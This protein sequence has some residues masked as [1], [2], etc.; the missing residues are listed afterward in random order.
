MNNA[1]QS[2]LRSDFG[3]STGYARITVLLIALCCVCAGIAI[4]AVV[5]QITG[6]RSD[7][8]RLAVSTGPVTPD[9]LSLAFARAANQV[10]PCVAHIKVAE[11]EWST[12]EG[13]GSGVIVN[14]AG[15]ILT[16]A[17]VI[18][19]AA[20]IRVKLADG[21]EYD[22]RVVG[23]DVPTDLAVLKIQAP[24]PLPAA[25]MGDSDK[26]NVGDWVLAI[27]SPFGLKQTVTAG[28]ISARDREDDAGGTPFQQFLQTDA[29]IN[30][31][32]SGGP[33]VNLGGEVIGINTQIATPTGTYS[34]IG[35]ALPSSTAVEIYNQLVASG[36]VRRAFLGVTP[37]EMTPQIA[38]LNRISDGQGVVIREL[39]SNTGPAAR[40]G[41][42]SGDVVTSINGNKVKTVRE[43]IRRIASLPVGSVASIEY[44]RAGE[45]RTCS[46]KLEERQDDSAPVLQPAV[47]PNEKRQSSPAI[48]RRDD[49]SGRDS[50]RSALGISVRSITNDF[51]RAEGLEGVEGA[52]ITMVE[53]G[54]IADRNGLG[55]E[56][57]IVDI[58]NKS[59]QSD[60]DFLKATRQLRSGDDVV[61]KVLRRQRGPLRRSWIVSFTMP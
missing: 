49:K 26:L 56:D 18:R 39:T 16:N 8:N 21:T 52:Y 25:R 34:G 59:I 23:T 14:E 41:L 61:I 32:N 22:A 57:I 33:L 13:S 31:G 7:D 12:R 11:S 51:A 55:I 43:L 36:R 37:Q 60:E 3:S 27:G 2:P 6:V 54:S 24:T 28:I 48:P 35:F 1:G 44:V 9:S 19:G 15:F 40:S 17:H 42:K 46:V 4:G 47:P 58:N 53:P 5:R 45:R 50:T 10:E 20:R 38:R 30:P 29:A